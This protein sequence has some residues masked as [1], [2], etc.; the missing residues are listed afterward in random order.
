MQHFENTKERLFVELLD[1]AGFEAYFVGGCNRDKILAET[2]G[3]P[4]S[5]LD[6]DIATSATPEEVENVLKSVGS[7]FDFVGKNYGVLIVDGIEIAQF[8]S[9]EYKGNGDG[10][11]VVTAVRSLKVDSDRRDFTINAIYMDRY[12]NIIDPHNGI[13]DLK[14]GIIRAINNPLDRFKEDTSRIL[15]LFYF[16]ARFNFTIDEVT[17][18]V[19]KE[20]KELLNVTP[21]ELKGKILKKVISCNCLSAYLI[22]IEEAGLLEYVLPEIAHTPNMP[23]N[24][25]YHHRDVFWHIIEVI[26]AAERDY[27][28][29]LLYATGGLFHDCEKGKEGVRG[30]NREGQP[31][32]LEHEAKGV[33]PT[34]K[35]LIRLQ[36]G[37]DFADEVGFLVKHHGLR[38]PINPKRKS[39]V[40]AL[41]KMSA[42]ARN[43]EH[44]KE[45]VEKLFNFMLLDAQGFQP[46]FARET[47]ELLE[48]LRPL[49][50][51]VLE[52]QIFYV[53]ELPI[54]GKDLISLGYPQGKIIR[55]MLEDFVIQ[56]L[57]DKERCLTIAENR[58]EKL[59]S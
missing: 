28:A 3:Q 46:D 27:P 10:K 30:V 5:S 14:D 42:D 4:V 16:A 23:Q 49:F 13:Q 31:N 33:E 45:R 9:E 21:E 43:K 11:P 40:S 8:R 37:S 35:A 36:F 22:L 38:L 41:R 52:E 1:D 47:T 24:P 44:L 17:L 26:Q 53:S 54:N 6:I 18:S 19:V 34:K 29:E 48:T 55:E 57:Q 39:I 2:N 20:N 32:D 56:N 12:G 51:E 50:M 25:K 7:S 59:I 15:R 58:L